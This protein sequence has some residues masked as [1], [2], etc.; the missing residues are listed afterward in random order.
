MLQPEPILMISDMNEM[1]SQKLIRF[2]SWQNVTFYQIYTVTK[3]MT[4]KIRRGSLKLINPSDAKAT[5]F[6][7]AIMQRFWKTS[8]PS[9]VGI[10]WIALTEYSQMSIHMPGFE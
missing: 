9:H 3:N 10:H 2:A 7:S 6:Q 5:F 8:K 1:W 4:L